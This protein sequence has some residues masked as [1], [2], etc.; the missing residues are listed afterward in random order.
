MPYHVESSD[1]LYHHHA[2]SQAGIWEHLYE[3]AV[4]DMFIANNSQVSKRDATRVY[5]VVW[6]LTQ[7]LYLWTLVLSPQV[8]ST[9]R[10]FYL[11]DK[12]VFA[13]QP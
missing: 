3:R 13:W 8:F 9:W 5:I 10:V 12:A 4:L 2:T 1:L 11:Y 6:T 7:F